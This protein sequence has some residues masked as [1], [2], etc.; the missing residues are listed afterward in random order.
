M[1]AVVVVVVVGGGGGGGGV[2]FC[3]HMTLS[4]PRTYQIMRKYLLMEVLRGV[5]YDH[6]ERYDDAD[7]QNNDSSY[8]RGENCPHQYSGSLLT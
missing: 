3:P 1:V 6:E 4:I 2:E 7:T 8:V 5:Q